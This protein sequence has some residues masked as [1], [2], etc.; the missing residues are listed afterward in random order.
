MPEILQHSFMQRALLAGLI[1]AVV[2]PLIG[3][4]LVLR[5]LS[6]IADTLSHVALAG[7]AIGL[8]AG[9]PPI[10]AAL[11]VDLAGG[12][13]IEAL[14]TRGRLS[15]EAALAVFLSGGLAV[16][17]V[18]IG[19]ARGFTVDLFG[20]L[21][22]SITTVAPLDLWVIGA[23]GA[24]TAG[25]VLVLYKD[26]FAVT[27]DEEAARTSGMPVGALNLLLTVLTALVV[28]L[29][30][31]IVGILLVSA[32]L[33]IPALAAMR[34]ATSFRGTVG[35]AVA[36]AVGAVLLGLVAAFYLDVAAGGAIV[37]VALGMFA[38]ASV[39]GRGK[40]V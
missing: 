8:F 18:L 16:A 6:L 3:V 37:L 17:I 1:I 20:Y 2:F 29:S 31:R 23:L 25:T 26:L 9:I 35:A 30:M 34:V 5:R 40:A 39:V 4:F 10:L 13:G 14:R 36:F 12:L 38:A 33:V 28:V 22:G 21:F 19:L 32:L 11:V 7:I 24:V 27:F 15:G